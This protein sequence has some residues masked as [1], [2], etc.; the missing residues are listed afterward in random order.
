MT[1]R[2]VALLR[3]AAHGLIGAKAGRPGDVVR[4]MTCM[5]GQDLPG[6]LTSVTLRT[7]SGDRGE[8]EAA[9]TA[10]EIVRSWPMRGTL[11]L[12]P[13]EDLGWM[14][15]LTT[16]RLMAGAASRRTNLELSLADIERAREVA[17]DAL[18]GG[19]S[20]DRAGIQEVW[21]AA[22]IA[23]TGQRGYHLIWSL[24]QTGTL[25]WGPLRGKEQAL[26]LL[27]EWVPAP[28]RLAREEALGEW[29]RR[30][31]ASHG[32]ATVADFG[33]WT[34]LL[35]ADVKAGVALARP[36]LEELEVDGTTYLMDPATPERLAAARREAPVHQAELL[37][38]GF[39]E[40]M[41]G[42]GDRSAAL[43]AEF[44]SRICPGGNGVFS[45]TV[46]VDGQVVGTWKWQGTGSK[47]AV[48]RT[49]FVPA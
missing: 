5:Q 36:A 12:V 24:S 47:R 48:V 39:D 40:F 25:C 29:A 15:D 26:V 17:V 11:H 38:P 37:L 3:L 6:A 30:Y 7:T 34:K 33:W 32:P 22:G 1:P 21:D 28:R 46:V 18:R 16:G 14:L 35:A 13:A 19:R 42:Y 10:G 27:D 8:V 20:L 44:A 2:D 31:F 43:P 23:T 9:V 41:L 45:P 4:A 49:P